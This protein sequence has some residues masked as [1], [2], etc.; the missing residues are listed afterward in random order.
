M[1][2]CSKTSYQSGRVGCSFL[3]PAVWGYWAVVALAPFIVWNT[4]ALADI[5]LFHIFSQVCIL[6][7]MRLFEKIAVVIFLLGVAFRFFDIPGG[8]ILAT[9]AAVSLAVYYF[10]FGFLLFNGILLK[11]IFKKEVYA[12]TNAL[13]IILAVLAGYIIACGVCAVAF[14]IMRW[15]GEHIMRNICLYLCGV[16][17]ISSLFVWLTSGTPFARR[18]FYRAA[19]VVFL[20]LFFRYVVR[21]QPLRSTENGTNI[22]QVEP[23][24][25]IREVRAIMGAQ[26]TL[27]KYSADQPD[28][29]RLM[30]DA[31]F[32]ASDNVYIVIDESDSLVR[33]IYEGSKIPRQ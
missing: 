6:T 18:T 23:G 32:G 5:V 21:L 7:A 14:T 17:T 16:I 12:D 31:P 29:L 3:Q 13:K 8:G 26:G 24:M 28:E 10:L 33:Y 19:V 9:L 4:I 1:Q 30:Y 22:Q 11:K 20:L 15:P 27:L 2:N 25:H